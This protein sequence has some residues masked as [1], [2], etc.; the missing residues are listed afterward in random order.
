MYGNCKEFRSRQASQSFRCFIAQR[1]NEILSVNLC[2]PHFCLE[3]C[4]KYLF[5]IVQ[6]SLRVL[7]NVF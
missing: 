4:R 7:F 3:V 5:R 6:F 2:W 1:I